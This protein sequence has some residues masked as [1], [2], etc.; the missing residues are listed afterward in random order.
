MNFLD[1]YISL[2][3]FIISFCIGIFMVYISTPLPEIIIRYPTPLNSNKIIYKDIADLC[4]VYDKKEVDCS[5]KNIVETPIQFIKNKDKN[6]KSALTN[7]LE[8]NH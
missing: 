1:N 3:Y 2:K 6:N 8:K 5:N 7:I 4:Y